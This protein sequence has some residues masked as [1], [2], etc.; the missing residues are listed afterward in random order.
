MN[1]VQVLSAEL[2]FHRDLFF[3]SIEELSVCRGSF[4]RSTR[5]LDQ[6]TLFSLFKTICGVADVQGGVSVAEVFRD[7]ELGKVVAT[8]E[9]KRESDEGKENRSTQDSEPSSD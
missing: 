3:D 5:V 9:P 6:K 2:R 7:E 1:E 4:H 8:V